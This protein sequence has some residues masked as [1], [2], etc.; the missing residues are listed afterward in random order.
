VGVGSDIDLYEEY[1]A[2]PG[3]RTEGQVCISELQSLQI[4]DK[5]VSDH[6]PPI[7]PAACSR[8]RTD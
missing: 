3:V 4:R 5:D 1:D 6:R 8:G 7:I 2:M